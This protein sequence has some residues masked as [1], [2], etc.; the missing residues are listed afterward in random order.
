LKLDTCS[1]LASLCNKHQNLL[2]SYFSKKITVFNFKLARE[3]EE[4]NLV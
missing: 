2:S 3:V 1:T 4:I